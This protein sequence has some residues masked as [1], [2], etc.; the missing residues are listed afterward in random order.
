VGTLVARGVSRDEVFTAIARECAGCRRV[1]DDR[2]VTSCALGRG[3]IAD[4]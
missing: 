4:L 3:G 2:I 1:N